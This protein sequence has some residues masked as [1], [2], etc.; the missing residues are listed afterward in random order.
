MEKEYY[1]PNDF[2]NLD[3]DSAMIQA[4]VDA[5]AESGAKVVIPRRNKR[6]GK[7][8][9]NITKAVELHTGSV[10]ILDNCCLRLA[11]G[12]FCNVFKN[13]NGRKALG[14]TIEGRQYDIRITGIGNA[15]LD[16]GNHN[17]LTEKT[18]FTNGMPGIIENTMIH[19]HNAER[20]TIENMRIINQ[21][22]WGMTFHYVSEGRI[23]NIEFMAHNNA[24]NQDGID[25]RTGCNRF[26]IENITGCTG[27]DTVALTCLDG[28]TERQLAV[29]GMD[30]DLHSVIVR[31][32]STYVTGNHAIVRLLNHG[33]KK[34]YNIIVENI[35]DRS[36]GDRFRPGA[37]V[38]IG[39][40]R[41]YS[42]SGPAQLGDTF[43]IT[44]RNVITCARF[45]VFISCTLQDAFINNIQLYGT[46]GT[47]VFFSKGTMRNIHISDVHYS[48]NCATSET[49]LDGGI[50]FKFDKLCALYFNESDCKDLTVR[51]VTAGKALSAVFGGSGDVNLIADGIIRLNPETKLIDGESIKADLR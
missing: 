43:G 32:V 5:A 24:P 28:R 18:Q 11:D 38:R 36:D 41:Y 8:F 37:A 42:D 39:E 46:A 20:V 3:S 30:P 26:I 29:E 12:V 21:R 15:V 35:L 14:K 44:V 16:G 23:S 27:D 22:H 47:G 7:D 51:G 31:N 50:L 2:M 45:G 33:G 13:S 10:V 49:F 25:L 40:Q 9:W 19:F 6:T 1:S 34:L 48:V 17:G 4:A